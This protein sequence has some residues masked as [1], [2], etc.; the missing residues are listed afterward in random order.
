MWTLQLGGVTLKCNTKKECFALDWSSHFWTVPL[1]VMELKAHITQN[2]FWI[3]LLSAS[4][5]PACHP[6]LLNK[7]MPAATVPVALCGSC[8]LLLSW[9]QFPPHLGWVLLF[10]YSVRCFFILC[11]GWD[12][13]EPLPSVY[14]AWWGFIPCPVWDA[15][16]QVL[17]LL[18]KKH[19]CVP[20]THLTPAKERCW[21]SSKHF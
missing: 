10:G 16:C 20:G 21:P 15:Q 17:Q 5:T 12:R 7:D 2:G 14:W 1:T 13:G 3:V 9:A 18:P 8:F 11:Y 19:H 6:L 4:A